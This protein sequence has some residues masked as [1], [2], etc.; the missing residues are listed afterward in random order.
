MPPNE[1]N[2]R[3][4]Q[5]VQELNGFIGLKKAYAGAAASRAELLDGA[6]QSEAEK[7]AGALLCG[8]ADR[9]RAPRRHCG[10]CCRRAMRQS[11]V[12]AGAA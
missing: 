3:K 7:L 12:R 2:Y 5:Y 8:A 11:C 4:K 9:R 10:C 1:L 6:P